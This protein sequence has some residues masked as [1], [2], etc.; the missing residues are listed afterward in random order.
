MFLFGLEVMA[1]LR[2]NQSLE[3]SMDRIETLVEI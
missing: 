1:W 2:K 3:R